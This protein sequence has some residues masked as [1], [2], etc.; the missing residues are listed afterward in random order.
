MKYNH[1]PVMLNE[2]VAGLDVKKGE[3]VVDCTLGG[4]GYTKAIS[5]LVGDRGKVLSIDADEMAIKNAKTRIKNKE[6]TE[7]I[8]LVND[9]FSNITDIIQKN[10]LEKIDAAV[11]DL[12]LSSAQLADEKRGFSFNIDAPLIMEFGGKVE[13]SK[14]YYIVNNYR[15]E[16]LEKII[17]EYGEERY[18]GRIAKAII[19]NRPLKTTKEL[20]ETI[21]KAVPK[22]YERG[23][24]HPSTRTFQALRIATN[25][26]LKSLREAL[27]GVLAS[28]K[29][30]GRIAVVSFHSLEDRIVKQFFKKESLACVCPPK[31]PIC[32]CHHQ[33]KLK[34]ITKKALT[35]SAEEIKNNSRARS[36][37]L[38]VA[39]KI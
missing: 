7:N 6:L 16:D 33:P 39:E 31:A 20:S 35:P 1:T 10:G 4:G 8:I 25:D 22:N 27:T 9:N 5:E 13:T 37:K 2:V 30:T 19:N 34:I 23:R 29:K 32:V 12:G 28:L 15:F 21:I 36:A 17:R 3:I 38:R 11:F 18:A 24:I 14:T 26:E